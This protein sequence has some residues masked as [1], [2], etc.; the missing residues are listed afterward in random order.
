MAKLESYPEFYKEESVS[1]IKRATDKGIKLK[2]INIINNIK[3]P[4]CPECLIDK[5]LLI[6]TNVVT[7][8]YHEEY[9]CQ[10]CGVIFTRDDL[11]E[12]NL[13]GRILLHH[14]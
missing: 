7:S 8:Y 5:G 13:K 2:P 14:E 11:V 3:I 4:Y 6:Q 1:F 9:H 10:T 12:E